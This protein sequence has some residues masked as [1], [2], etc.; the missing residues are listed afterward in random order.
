MK[1]NRRILLLLWLLSLLGISLYGGPITYGIFT[2]LTLIPA[3]SFLYIF[4]VMVLFKIYQ[5]LEG[6][7]IIC[8][9]PLVFRFILQNESPILFAGIRVRFYSTFS[10][11]SGLDD[12]TEYELLP[13][14]GI[15]RKTTLLCRCRGNYEAGIKAIEITDFFRLFSFS[16]RNREP[17]KI[18]VRPNIIHLSQLGSFDVLSSSLKDSSADQSEADMLMRE[19]IAGDDPRLINWKVSGS[20]GTLMVRQR[21]GVQQQRVGIL[22]DPHRYSSQAE[23]YLPAENKV[24]EIVIALNVFFRENGIPA[25]TWFSDGLQSPCVVDRISGFERFYEQMDHYHFEETHTLYP[26]FDEVKRSGRF[27]DKK[28]IFF[29]LQEWNHE[30][31]AAAEELTRQ[32]IT[33]SAYIVSNKTLTASAS[34]IRLVPIAPDADLQEVM[35]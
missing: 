22:M 26:L 20:L 33:V 5:N 16:Y 2:L 23:E 4:T 21:I 8:G 7:D 14:E 31:S 29:V 6:N 1:R 3:V 25:E 19:Y 15:E 32:G 35:Q 24:L 12:Q 28:Y 17:L 18:H 11:I 27:A 10:T 13:T 30:T 34:G 9:K